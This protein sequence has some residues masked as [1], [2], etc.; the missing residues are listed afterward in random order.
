MILGV[1]ILSLK[2]HNCNVILSRPRSVLFPCCSHLETV[3]CPVTN[4]YMFLFETKSHPC[5]K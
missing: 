3:K 5:F 4:G 1:D 2:L